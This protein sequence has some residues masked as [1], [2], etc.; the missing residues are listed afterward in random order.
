MMRKGVSIESGEE[1]I[2]ITSSTSGREQEPKNTDK[3]TSSV[4]IGSNIKQQDNTSVPSPLN[5]SSNVTID[6]LKTTSQPSP[7]SPTIADS[8]NITTNNLKSDKDNDIVS[9]SKSTRIIPIKI[10][11]DTPKISESQKQSGPTSS[12]EKVYKSEIFC[13][14]KNIECLVKTVKVT[15]W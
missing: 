1:Q 12:L 4:L 15:A 10:E 8:Q 9:T 6:K 3:L 2:A 7:S 5:K 13:F 14:Q 11:R